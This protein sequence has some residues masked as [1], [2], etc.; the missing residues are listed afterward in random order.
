MQ[1]HPFAANYSGRAPVFGL[2]FPACS[3]FPAPYTLIQCVRILAWI[4]SPA[5]VET[6]ASVSCTG[7]WQSIQFFW[8][9]APSR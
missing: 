8:I 6:I 5:V 9:A 4:R 1:R 3:P 7:I 2:S